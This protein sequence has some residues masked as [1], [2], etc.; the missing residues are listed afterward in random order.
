[1]TAT[2]SRYRSFV[3]YAVPI[4]ILGLIGASALS[5]YGRF[6]PNK[7]RA[8][9]ERQE[10]KQGMKEA[11]KMVA[12]IANH[13]KS[14]RIIKRRKVT[15]AAVPLFSKD[16]DWKEDERVQKALNKLSSDKSIELW[17]AL[18]QRANDK[19]YCMTTYSWNNDDAE[20][21][22]V[23]DVCS[24]LAYDRLCNVFVKHLPSVAPY[25]CPVRL[26]SIRDDLLTW[27]KERKRKSL[28]ELQIEACEMA[29]RKLRQV[30][31]NIVSD[32]EKDQGR[33]PFG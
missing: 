15:P 7:G 31:S 4:S 26:W 25:G 23:G 32:K 9:D 10:F 33:M 17:E 27:R 12:A 19:Q 20:N 2:S 8:T 21:Y 3:S 14:P 1:M 18:V 22:T 28:Y 6:A 5:E 24:L 30:S 13:N 16:Y 29:I 11:T